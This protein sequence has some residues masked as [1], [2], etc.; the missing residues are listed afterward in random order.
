MEMGKYMDKAME[1]KMGWEL[2]WLAK[3]G[4]R[5]GTIDQLLRRVA[6]VVCT[7]DQSFAMRGVTLVP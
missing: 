2:T 3:D 4:G 1:V 5:T 7:V 6:G